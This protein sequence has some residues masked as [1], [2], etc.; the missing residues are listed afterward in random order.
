[1]RQFLIVATLCALVAPSVATADQ[2]RQTPGSNVTI[3][4]CTPHFGKS[5]T[6][7]MTTNPGGTERTMSTTVGDPSVLHLSFTNDAKVAAKEVDV[8]LVERDRVVQSVKDSGTFARGETIRHK[9][10]LAS[11]VSPL[12]AANAYCAVTAVRY[13]DGKSWS[14]PAP[15]ATP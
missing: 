8:S 9:F 3:T 1:M 12:G 6:S 11:S 5:D 15:A 13:A 7:S 2:Q 14:A 10:L 4:D